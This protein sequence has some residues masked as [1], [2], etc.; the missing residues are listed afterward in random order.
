MKGKIAIYSSSLLLPML[1][2][3]ASVHAGSTGDLPKLSRERLFADARAEASRIGE[4]FANKGE[5]TQL[6]HRVNEQEAV[7]AEKARHQHQKQIQNRYEY[8]GDSTRNRHTNMPSGSM[9]GRRG[10]GGGGRR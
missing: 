1:M 5:A 2:V 4:G 10:G 8:A 7:A 3:G 6:R 9:N